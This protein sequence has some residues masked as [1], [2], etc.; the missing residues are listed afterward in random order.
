MLW[1]RR[2][3][4]HHQYICPIPLDRT[5]WNFPRTKLISPEHLFKIQKKINISG[6][7]SLKPV[8]TRVASKTN[9]LSLAQL[10]QENIPVGCVSPDCQPYILW[11]PPD[12]M[13]GGP[14]T[15]LN[16]SPVMATR[17]H[18][19]RWAPISYVWRGLERGGVPIRWGPNH[20]G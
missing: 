20:Y 10:Q 4:G 8:H 5:F 12:A 19:Q 16:R 3:Y 11:Q 13:G 9:F 6:M 14:M 1:A 18:E 15:S 17:Y 7:V 2:E